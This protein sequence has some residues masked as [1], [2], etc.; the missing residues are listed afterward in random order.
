MIYCT[1]SYACSISS[2]IQFWTVGSKYDQRSW[3]CWRMMEYFCIVHRMFWIWS[4]GGWHQEPV[5]SVRAMLC[6]WSDLRI[7]HRHRRL[8]HVWLTVISLFGGCPMTVYCTSVVTSTNHLG[9]QTNGGEYWIQLCVRR[10]SSEMLLV[11]HADFQ[12][13][14][15]TCLGRN[16]KSFWFTVL[17]CCK[18]KWYIV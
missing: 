2:N 5:T 12:I 7:R 10:Q 9:L 11:L 18:E 8:N 3:M 16:V 13:S 1:P 15:C 6:A 17:V 4:Y 14:T